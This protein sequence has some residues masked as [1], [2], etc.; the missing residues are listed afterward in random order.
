M[1]TES[2][3]SVASACTAC[4]TWWAWRAFPLAAWP[5]FWATASS[6][7]SSCPASGSSS[8]YSK[9]ATTV[10]AVLKWGDFLRFPPLL[11]PS[12]QR[13]CGDRIN[14]GDH[15]LVQSLGFKN[16]HFGV[17]DGRA[18]VAGCLPLRSPVRSVC[19]HFCILKKVKVL[20]YLPLDFCHFSL[21]IG[22]KHQLIMLLSQNTGSSCQKSQH[23]LS[24]C[25]FF[26]PQSDFTIRSVFS[27]LCSAPLI[28]LSGKDCLIK[29]HGNL[30]EPVWTVA[31]WRFTDIF[32]F[33]EPDWKKDIHSFPQHCLFNL[34]K[35]AK[36]SGSE[37]DGYQPWANPAEPFQASGNCGSIDSIWGKQEVF[38]SA[39]RMHKPVNAELDQVLSVNVG[40]TVY[41]QVQA[42]LFSAVA[43]VCLLSIKC[44]FSSWLIPRDS[45]CRL[46]SCTL[47]LSD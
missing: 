7:W 20:K 16:L 39:L 41:F 8:L 44:V 2:A 37:D 43:I 18:A 10:M 1:C 23:S 45:T 33:M 46:L 21:I 30:T 38:P 19:A 25:F 6:P 13:I 14:S 40:N 42:S 4:S 27:H 22:G 11:F 47:G 3:P 15:W 31:S 34:E 28:Y 5:V 12:P 17:S 36:M 24:F 32:E 35:C 26:S 29:I 9:Y